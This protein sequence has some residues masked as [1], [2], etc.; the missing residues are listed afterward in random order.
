MKIKKMK[1]L[2]RAQFQ[3]KTGDSFLKRW[4]STNIFPKIYFFQV[5]NVNFGVLGQKTGTAGPTILE[6]FTKRDQVFYKKPRKQKIC[7]GRLSSWIVHIWNEQI[8]S[9]VFLARI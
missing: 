6:L 7:G 9:T 5:N 3:T 8:F 2:F 4:K 1:K